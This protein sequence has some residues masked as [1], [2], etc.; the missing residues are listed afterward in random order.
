MAG[1]NKPSEWQN[2][3]KAPAPWGEIGSS[4]LIIATPA[5]SLKRIFNPEQV[6][7]YWDKVPPLN[8]LSTC[9]PRGAHYALPCEVQPG[10]RT[11]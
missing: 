1:S 8:P 6:V 4:K 2:I 3:L 10:D 11:P 9:M 5:S 7:N